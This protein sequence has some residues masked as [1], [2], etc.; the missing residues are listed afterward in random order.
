MDD[1]QT[2]IRK[3]R[4][5]RERRAIYRELKVLRKEYRERKGNY[6]DNLVRGSKVVLATLHGASGY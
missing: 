5:A 6:I 4:N 1:K 3:T 2:S